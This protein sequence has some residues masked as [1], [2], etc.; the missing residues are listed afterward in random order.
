MTFE[1]IIYKITGSCGKVYIGST[2][3][4][5]KRIIKHNINNNTTCSKKLKKPLQFEIIRTDDYKLVKT[6]YLVEQYYIDIYK[7][8]NKKRAYTNSFIRK[9]IIKEIYQNNKESTL[10]KARATYQNN[11]VERRQQS[12]INYHKNK[13]KIKS[14]RMVKINCP[15]CNSITN[16]GGMTRHQKTKKCLKL[17]DSI[18][19]AV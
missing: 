9:R 16:K 5:Y 4:Y 1:G 19:P 15:Y 6:M 17:R 2:T 14:K 3:D 18:T 11:I 13:E 7:C 8:V 10:E 12:L